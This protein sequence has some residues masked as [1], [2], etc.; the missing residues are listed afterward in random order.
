MAVVRKLPRSGMLVQHVVLADP[1]SQVSVFI[2]SPSPANPLR[3]R[4]FQHWTHN[5]Y[6]IMRHGHRVTV[7]GRV[8][9]ATVRMIGDSLT[10]Q[11]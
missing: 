2:E 6:Q 1:L 5:G 9:A 4:L 8:P 7:L 10:P 11:P 3:N